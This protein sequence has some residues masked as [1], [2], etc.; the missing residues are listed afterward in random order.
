MKKLS[1]VILAGALAAGAG[2]FAYK[3]Y[4]ESKEKKKD[5][6]EAAFNELEDCEILDDEETDTAEDMTD[7]EENTVADTEA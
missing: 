2:I 5:V 1:F 6:I 4:K 3:K 7:N